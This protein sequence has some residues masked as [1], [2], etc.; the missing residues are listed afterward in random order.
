M[1]L[2]K[3]PYFLR[4]TYLFS[5][6]SPSHQIYSRQHSQQSDASH[7]TPPHPHHVTQQLG[8]LSPLVAAGRRTTDGQGAAMDEP[9][10]DEIE[11]EDELG[12]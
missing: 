3:K 1:F 10:Y 11:D 12:E 6:F 9:D 4:I 7:V 5:Y 2:E 8:P